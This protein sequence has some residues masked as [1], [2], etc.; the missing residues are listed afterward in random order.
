M[1][2]PWVNNLITTCSNYDNFYK[3]YYDI[4]FTV[5]YQDVFY[6]FDLNWIIVDKI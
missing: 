6:K 4:Y 1:I 2:L 3:I 5:F